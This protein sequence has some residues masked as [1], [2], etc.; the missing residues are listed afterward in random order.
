MYVPDEE[1]GE[2]CHDVT[3]SP[4]GDV[5]LQHVSPTFE[6]WTWNVALSI[7][8]HV[9]RGVDEPASKKTITPVT[10]STLLEFAPP[11]LA[12]AEEISATEARAMRPR[13]RAFVFIL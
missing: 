9:T 8:F 5:L 2:S 4:A 7:E 6:R 12:W 3:V 1:S 13:I 11:P 10:E